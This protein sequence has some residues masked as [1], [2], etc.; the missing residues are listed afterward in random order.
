MGNTVVK[1]ESALHAPSQAPQVQHRLPN[2][3]APIV[4]VP[5]DGELV[6]ADTG[7]ETP[8]KASAIVNTNKS[9]EKGDTTKALA[10]VRVARLNVNYVVSLAPLEQSISEVAQANRL[11]ANSDYYAA[12]QALREAEAGIEYD[13]IH[14]VANLGNGNR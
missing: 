13:E 4:W 12:G 5:I 3:M 10:E 1:A 2:S 14:D 7:E 6:L 8:A 9:L 11:M